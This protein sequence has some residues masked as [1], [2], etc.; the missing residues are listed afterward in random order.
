MGLNPAWRDSL[1]FVMVGGGGWPEGSNLTEINAA[2][3]LIIEDMETIEALA[4]DSGAYFNEV[5]APD[6]H[7]T[8]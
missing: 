8:L 6:I 1:V 3:Q 2:R 5:R 7:T 4:P